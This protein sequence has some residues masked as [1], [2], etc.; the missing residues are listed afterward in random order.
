MMINPRT[1]T[2]PAVPKTEPTKTAT[3]PKRKRRWVRRIIIALI[4]IPLILV[5]TV[6]IVGQTG[7]MK[8]LVEPALASQLGV[9]VET[10][11]IKLGPNGTI[12]I[13]DAV[14]T[15]ETIDGKA[16]ELI[17]VEQAVIYVDWGALTQGRGVQISSIVIDEPTLRV[18]QDNDTGMLN[19]AELQFSSSDGGGATPSIEL[20]DGTIEIG[21]HADGTYTALKVMTMEGRI[22]PADADGNSSFTFVALPT[23]P[24]IPGPIAPSDGGIINLSGQLSSDGVDA[25]LDGLR[26][27]DWP[28]DFVPSRSR[29][30][31]QRI[32]LRGELAP[33][34]LRVDENGEVEVV[35]TLDGVSLNLPFSEDGT[36][37]GTG[38]LLR[39]RQTRGRVI[40][41]T[42][43]LRADLD[44]F[45]DELEYDV[46]LDYRGLDAQSAFDAVLTTE[47]RLDERF[48]PAKFLPENV[49]SKLER[50]ENPRADVAAQVRL[51]RNEGAEVRVSGRA[52]LS[53]GSATYKKF[54]YPFHSLQGVISFDPDKLVVEQITGIGPTGAT[55]VADGLFSPLGEESVVTLN[56]EVAGVPIDQHMLDAM[57]DQQRELISA[58]FNQ[59]DY[60]N[61]ISEGLLMS[62]EQRSSLLA[63]RDALRK[64]LASWVD[65]IDGDQSA[66]DTIAAQIYTIERELATPEFAF[67]GSADVGVVLRRHPER[68]ADNRWTTDVVVGLT[69][70]GMVPGH[71]PLPII[72][73][74]IEIAITEEKVE[75]TGGE[76]AGLS[77]GSA[78]VSAF[79]D[80]TKPDSKPVVRISADQIPIDQ[81]LVAAIPGYYNDQSDDPEDISLR[82]ILDRMRLGG[83]MDCDAII[84]PRSDNRLG[85]DVEST[86]TR[87]SARP[88]YQGFDTPEDPLAIQ[89]GADPLALDD[90]YGTV[91]VT[92]ELIIV[93]LAAMLSSPELPLAPTPVSVLTQLTLPAKTRGSNGMRRSDGLLP[94]EFGP[95]VPGPELYALARIDG[96]DFAM[97]LHHAVA[98]VS[99]RIAR[100][101]LAY[102]DEFQP[103]GV[104]AIDARLEGFVGGA[105]N[106]SF[107]LDRVDSLAFD[108][109]GTR[110]QLGSSW[111][112]AELRLSHA[113]SLSFDGFLIPISADDRDAGVLNIH[114]ELPLTRP[115]QVLE[116]ETSTPI[117]LSYKDATLESP[118]S[119]MVINRFG[120]E[121]AQH[122]VRD[123]QL[124]GGFDLDV[125]LIPATGIHRIPE[126]AQSLGVLPMAIHGELLPSSL[127][128]TMNQREAIFD[129]IEG[130]VRFDGYKGSFDQIRATSDESS[131]G[132][133]G[134]WTLV[135]GEGLGMDLRVDAGGSLLDGPARAVLPD[136]IN[137]VIEQLE[138]RADG[139]VLI[140][141]LRIIA[142][143]W[144][145][146]DGMYDIRGNAVINEGRALIGLPIT[147]MSGDL[148]FAVQGTTDQVG[149]ELQ[150]EATRLRAGLLRVYDAKVDIIGDANNPGVILIPEIFAGMHGGR[151]AGSAQILPNPSDAQP[152]Y[153]MELHASGVR[154]APVFDDLLLPPEGLVG[155]PLPGEVS[156]LS[157]WSKAD[158][159]SRGSMLADLT[160]TGPVGV[161]DQRAGRGTVEIKGGSVLALPGLINLIEASNLS[162]PSGATIDL[163][164]ADF[165]ID[166]PTL[167][168]EQLS[169]SSKRIEILGYGTLSWPARELD[170]RFSS[171]AINPI[172]VVSAMIESLRDELITI[173]V[174]GTVAEPVYAANQFD[175]T[176]RL[177]NALL[178]KPLSEQQ[179][180]LREVE[181]Q[182]QRD[183]RRVRSSTNDLL[184]L[185][186]DAEP[187]A[188]DWDPQALVPTDGD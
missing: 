122:W 48:S 178:G 73:R 82:R 77:G 90:L 20:R 115:G 23:E 172:P 105:I 170:L 118:L 13:N 179:Q 165:Y 6:M 169:A 138:I 108:Y 52:S 27:E 185:P 146:P 97:P 131:I 117:E 22:D 127:S 12:I 49:I 177:F 143:G 141:G 96:L 104:V 36:L 34:T 109:D 129:S 152:H 41:G 123:N 103:D 59:E 76:Y 181:N 188:E 17:E 28:G 55:L 3:E 32:A 25:R 126:D 183:R 9:N 166:G 4:L 171:R 144:G 39:M 99:P 106:S 175:E 84:G 79:I 31:Y 24:G 7:V 116:L 174:T 56:L 66:K 54:R 33:T 142:E 88:I 70:A 83:V 26:L 180:R 140:E 137:R 38:D 91:Y 154:A 60:D 74:G 62:Q 111:G 14:F 130:A 35:L 149:Y 161:L 86:I 93:D 151:I 121:R 187:S 5:V 101:L 53:N 68:P 156:V 132:I 81:R 100:D 107:S 136:P 135:P 92:E 10:R 16:G 94:I 85:F 160:L 80:L 8:A 61:L 120:S 57:D 15:S 47:F 112:L 87:G 18:S 58:L 159:L 40:F 1:R 71:F 182:V 64:Q 176:R 75:L 50:F 186:S 63:D 155:P 128:L 162:F 98:V 78:M 21:E 45:I 95:P 30:L 158:D 153:W 168:F 67:G 173:G 114:G 72:A 29:E 119:R 124:R 110:F 139:G 184:H 145:K 134:H 37:T 2:E 69:E 113:P 133:E 65:A 11:S 157:G 102:E 44:G 51:Q 43:G 148:G 19:L 164:E 46:E 89:L 163:A 150:L 147:G 42:L 167:A 125:A